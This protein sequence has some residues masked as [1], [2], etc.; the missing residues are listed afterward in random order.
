MDSLQPNRSTSNLSVQSQNSI[1]SNS[2]NYT[3]RSLCNS[4]TIDRTNCDFNDKNTIDA[5]FAVQK[6]RRWK[7]DHYGDSNIK[8]GMLILP[9]DVILTVDDFK[10]LIF[11]FQTCNDDT[12]CFCLFGDGK[13]SDMPI[14]AVV[15]LFIL[16]LMFLQDIKV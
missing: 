8:N 6:T 2:S 4:I 3:G 14:L 15:Y 11:E 7:I 1:H 9:C 13:I 12:G 16:N 5:I 10:K